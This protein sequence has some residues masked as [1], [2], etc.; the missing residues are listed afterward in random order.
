MRLKLRLLLTHTLM[1]VALT[2][3]VQYV[4][5]NPIKDRRLDVTPRDVMTHVSLVKCSTTC[6]QTSWCVSANMAPDRSTCHLLSEEVSDVTSLELADGWSYI[7]KFNLLE[8]NVKV[9][10]V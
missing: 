9:T 5:V 8:L 1:H 6:R 4:I 2:S 10:A 3:P 7:R